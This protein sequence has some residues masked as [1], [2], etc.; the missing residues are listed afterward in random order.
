METMNIEALL[1]KMFGKQ[2]DVIQLIREERWEE[3]SRYGD[4]VSYE[5]VKNN[6]QWW[7]DQISDVKEITNEW[8]SC[9]Y[10]CTAMAVFYGRD[11]PE[12]A[13]KIN[14]LKQFFRDQLGQ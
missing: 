5:A 11:F 4:R 1:D 2:S 8:N 10:G 6:E 12:R 7:W 13:D 3:A 14:D 9:S